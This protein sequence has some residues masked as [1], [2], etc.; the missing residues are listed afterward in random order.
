MA[1]FEIKVTITPDSVAYLKKLYDMPS[2]VPSAIRRGLDSALQTVKK[3]LIERRLSGTGPF[4]PSEHRL[5]EVTGTLQ[6]SVY[7]R[8]SMGGAY[9]TGVIGS[10]VIY[11]PVHEY[12]AVI[13]AKN[14]PFLVFKIL[15]QTYRAKSVTIPERAPFRTEVESLESVALISGEVVAEVESLASEE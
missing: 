10:D 2:Q 6:E 3:N 13:S 12:G 15:G 8:T 1:D 7:V 14:A 5:G 11:A 4:P 9:V